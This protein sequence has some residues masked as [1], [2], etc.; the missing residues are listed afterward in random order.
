MDTSE[1]PS[2]PILLQYDSASLAL[3]CRM[4]RQRQRLQGNVRKRGESTAAPGSGLR[5][6]SLCLRSPLGAPRHL[7][8]VHRPWLPTGCPFPPSLPA[9]SWS[10][11][12][13]AV[14]KLGAQSKSG[15]DSVA[16]SFNA[17]RR[18][19]ILLKHARGQGILLT[20]PVGSQGHSG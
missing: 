5:C 10:K 9:L 6:C 17:G 7:G 3:L 13:G 16:E 12:E 8:G 15:R 19:P 14:P 20:A 11:R 1:S 4:G 18:K 2:L